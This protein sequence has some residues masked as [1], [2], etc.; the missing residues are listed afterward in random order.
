MCHQAVEKALKGFFAKNSDDAPPFT[1]NLK[2]LTEKSGIHELLT[3]DFKNTIDI[4]TPLNIE[5]RY[6]TYKEKLLQ[7]LTEDRCKEILEQTQLFI[8]WIRKQL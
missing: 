6:P 3:V 5:A 8:Q 1:H 4:L 2:H 7:Y